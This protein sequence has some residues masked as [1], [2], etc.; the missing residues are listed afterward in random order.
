L[1]SQNT[2]KLHSSAIVVDTHNDFL[3]KSVEHGYQFDKHL[4]GIT[5]SD[6]FRMDSGKIDIQIFSIWCEARPDAFAFANREIDSLYAIL[7]RNPDKLQIIYSPSDLKKVIKEKK[8][9][10]MI[11]VEGGHMIENDITK[12]DSLYK[13][14]TRY[15]T[16]T[17]NNSNPGPVQQWT[18]AKAQLRMIKKDCLLLVATWLKE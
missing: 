8:H 17:W 4:N 14:G 5:H 11:G 16:L 6:I 18:K 1:F 2:D 12:L 9:G 3:S 10:A 15:M 13:R 7:K